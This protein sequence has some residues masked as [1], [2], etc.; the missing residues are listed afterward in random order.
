[1]NMFTIS[2]LLKMISFSHVMHSVRE[3][4]SALK[5]TNRTLEMEEQISEIPPKVQ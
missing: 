2:G 5:S 1:M 4:I 3:N